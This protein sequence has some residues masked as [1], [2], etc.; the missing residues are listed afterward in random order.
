MIC[1]F[2]PFFQSHILVS[3]PPFPHS[4][5]A[6]YRAGVCGACEAVTSDVPDPSARSDFR[7]ISW[8]SEQS[9]RSGQL[10]ACME[11]W[12]RLQRAS[13]ERSVTARFT[14]VPHPP[15]APYGTGRASLRL[16]GGGPP[17]HP[18]TPEAG[19]KRSTRDRGEHCRAQQ[20]AP[21]RQRRQARHEEDGGRTERRREHDGRE[22][23]SRTEEHGGGR[24]RP[25]RQVGEDGQGRRCSQAREGGDAQAERRRRAVRRKSAFHAHSTAGPELVQLLTPEGERVEHPDYAIDLTAGGTPRPVPRHGAHP[26]LRRR[27]DLAP[28]PGRT[29]PV[30][31]A[32]GPGGGADRLRRARCATTT[33]SSPP[34]ASTASPGAA[35]WTRRSCWACSA[36]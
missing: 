22:R 32:A 7:A 13:T 12:A 16:T 31:L 26:A 5:A 3:A 23:R 19:Q 28:A 17:G 35:E 10:H 18:A 15:R 2:L 20:T 4:G 24:R 21:Q 29:G 25:D 9:C 36:V 14:S 33:T 27:G 6:G 30:G 1:V 11:V 34:T 8:K